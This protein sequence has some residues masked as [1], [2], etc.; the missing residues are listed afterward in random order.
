MH[1]TD[2]PDGLEFEQ[3]LIWQTLFPQETVKGNFQDKQNS[4]AYLVSTR[5][6]WFIYHIKKV[7]SMNDQEPFRPTIELRRFVYHEPF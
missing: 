3:F 5:A 6:S 2:E 4:I 1:E 7:R